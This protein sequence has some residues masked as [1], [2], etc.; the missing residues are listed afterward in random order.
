MNL[1]TV[2][3]ISI[4]ILIKIFCTLAAE[5]YEHNNNNNNSSSRNENH[6]DGNHSSAQLLLHS[7]NRFLIDEIQN[8]HSVFSSTLLSF[9]DRFQRHMQ[10][11]MAG[12][13]DTNPTAVA[14][15]AESVLQIVDRLQDIVSNTHAHTCY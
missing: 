7:L 12:C 3:E 6:D 14:A 5:E 8:L 1:P 15:V 10:Q 13:E 2:H 4:A 9:C 11:S